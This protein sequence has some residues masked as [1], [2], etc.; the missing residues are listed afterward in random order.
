MNESERRLHER[1][2]MQALALG[3][4]DERI[5]RMLVREGLSNI[6]A[7]EL[8]RNA[9]RDFD[10]QAE[11]ADRL[12]FGAASLAGGLLLA[13]FSAIGF[14]ILILPFWYGGRIV[15]VLILITGGGVVLGIGAFVTGIIQ[16]RGNPLDLFV[17][18][19]EILSRWFRV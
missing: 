3:N 9:H 1:K 7:G 8:L 18:S 14:A 2:I 11:R 19:K 13:I 6:D 4:S 17:A 15:P 10:P 12:N 5:Y 16:L